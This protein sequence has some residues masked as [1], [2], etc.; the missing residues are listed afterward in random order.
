MFT[1][2]RGLLSTV[3]I[4]KSFDSQ[5]HS[6][7]YWLFLIAFD[8]N[9]ITPNELPIAMYK[10]ISVAYLISAKGIWVAA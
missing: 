5:I 3:Q 6:I 4:R 9:W 8:L 1:D 2:F 10:L 7:Y